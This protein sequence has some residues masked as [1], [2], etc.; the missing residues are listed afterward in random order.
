[1]KSTVTRISLTTSAWLVF[2][3]VTS[4]PALESSPPQG[5]DRVQITFDASEAEAVLAIVATLKSGGSPDSASWRGLFENRPYVRLKA[6]ETGMGNEFTDERFRSFVSSPPLAARADSLKRTLQAW[7]RTDLPASARRVLAYLP[8]SARIRAS[9]Y[10]VIKPRQN[11]FV[12]EPSTDPAIFLYVDPTQSAA[13]F[14][15]TVA[16]EM[17]HIGY[18]SVSARREAERAGLPHLVSQTLTWMG[19]FGEGFAM[20]AAAGSADVHPHAASPASE[21]ARWDHDMANFNRDLKVLEKFFLDVLNGKFSSDEEIQEAA[22]TFYGEQGPWYTVGY[23]MAVVVEKHF[24]RQELIVCMQDPR[25]LLDRYNAAA[26]ALNRGGGS[27]LA[28]WSPELFQR[29]GPASRR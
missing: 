24:G 23:R 19:A 10:P 27:P 3:S 28:L 22:F 29:I 5:R 20:L 1:M 13:K 9:V 7:K 4:A 11:S 16:H 25:R 15:N 17:H 6:R 12:F 21:R 26:A 18:S 14:E 8:D 2:A